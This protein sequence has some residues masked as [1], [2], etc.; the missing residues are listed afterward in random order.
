MEFKRSIS[1]LLP[2]FK[3]KL[4]VISGPRQAGKTHLVQRFLQPQLQLNL[5]LAEDRLRFKKLYQF[6]T[7]WY[8]THYGP[9]P[10]SSKELPN[11]PIVFIDEIQ[12][13]KGWRNTLK[14][15]YDKTQHFLDFVASGSSA[16]ELRRQDT[17]GESLAGRAVWLQLFPLSF[18]EYLS[19]VAPELKL[20]PAWRGVGGLAQQAKTLAPL[21]KQLRTHWNNFVH[22]GSFPENLLRQ[23]EVF[24]QQ[25][26]SSYQ[27]ALL[28]RDL[29]DLGTGKDVERVYQ[30]YQLLL[31]GLG[32]TFSLKSLAQ[33]LQ[34]S[35]N[36]IKS[37]I[38][39]IRQ[40]LMGFELPVSVLSK[41]KQIRKEKKFYPMDFCFV[42]A[43]NVGARFESTLACLLFRGLHRELS[44]FKPH[45]ELGFY[46]D[47]QQHE[48]DF[49]IR[50]KQ[51]IHTA[52]EC[53]QKAKSPKKIFECIQQFSPEACILAVD[54]P[55]Q[56]QVTE[57]V[58][59]L[60]VELIAACLE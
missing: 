39:A 10:P 30:V 46:R 8:Q 13:S 1:A 18:R 56:C 17:R 60:S 26:L 15:T 32:S 33:T 4:L 7:D 21:A 12:K 45:L 29:R 34:V 23:D 42:E 35:P 52:I 57:G 51:R 16:F 25:W 20:P 44:G 48:V 40:V 41:H 3:N 9:I 6:L 27:T 24:L 19:S 22:F 28:D 55:E 14:G 37:D 49:I 5:D 59:V 54:V 11:K 36:T 43:H 50:S 38:A 53:K 31:E 47:Y 2:H 58:W